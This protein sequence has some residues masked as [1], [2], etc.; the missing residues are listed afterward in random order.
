MDAGVFEKITSARKFE[1]IRN[2][3]WKEWGSLVGKYK[4]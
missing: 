1:R 2:Q 4:E 3:I